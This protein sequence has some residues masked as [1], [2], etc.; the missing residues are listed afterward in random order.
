MWEGLKSEV[1]DHTIDVATLEPSVTPVS[2][3]T[4]SELICSYN[5]QSSG[6]IKVPG[7]AAIWQH[8]K[9]PVTVPRDPQD[10][11]PETR[12]TKWKSL[13][14]P[15][16]RAFEATALM[17][18]DFRL[19]NVDIVITRDMLQKLLVFCSKTR[20]SFRLKLFL[21]NNT[22]FVDRFFIE[23]T[24]WMDTGHGQSFETG[25]ARFPPGLESSTAH[26]R[27]LR[28]PLGDLSCMVGLAVD[29]SYETDNKAKGVD[30][31]E[32]TPTTMA[33]V[34]PQSTAAEVK[35]MFQRRSTNG[36][37]PQLWFGRTP[38]LIVGFHNEGTFNKIKVT[39]AAALF[40]AWETERQDDLRR[41][42]AF[43]AEL[44][45]GVRKC[46]GKECAA[47]YERDPTSRV[48]KFYSLAE[49]EPV[50]PVAVVERFWGKE[51][52]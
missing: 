37:M 49:T 51:G 16:Q 32:S 22:L 46:G 17:N 34:M 21:V 9:L 52:A 31:A 10:N 6:E 39:D 41:L 13:Q 24:E 38:W 29:A 4:P 47:I 50:L 44:R 1:P 23:A 26:D 35:S 14:Y 2:S 42:T 19:N 43:L 27:F 33:N 7:Y 36:I 25:F 40:K 45:E 12:P 8:P 30:R 48:I 20:Q 28:Y 18:P 5:R 15:F 11:K 3:K